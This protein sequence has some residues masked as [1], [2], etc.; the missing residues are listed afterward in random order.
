M[1]R[2]INLLPVHYNGDDTFMVHLYFNLHTNIKPEQSNTPQQ[3]PVY[4]IS[5]NF[6][7]FM[8][9]YVL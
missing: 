6:R 4:V 2:I 3:Y 9:A 8:H 5:P 1:D 7:V